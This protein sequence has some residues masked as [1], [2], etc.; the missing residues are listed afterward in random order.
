M[1]IT[2][3]TLF[4]EMYE[5]FTH[6]SIIGRSVEQGKVQVDFVQIR[7]FA[8][9]KYR[10][11]DDTPFG[12]GAGMVMKCQPVIDALNSVRTP[13]SY[14]MMMNPGGTSIPRRRPGS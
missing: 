5:N 13:E 4:P 6:T 1:R 12:G 11:M 10:H 9:D 2:F 7:D 3:V 8:L 14:C